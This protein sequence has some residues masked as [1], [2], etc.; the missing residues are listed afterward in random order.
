LAD[1]AGFSKGAKKNE[2]EVAKFFRTIGYEVL[3]DFVLRNLVESDF[4]YAFYYLKKHEKKFNGFKGLLSEVDR[5]K[6][7]RLYY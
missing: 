6:V 1:D 2:K 4:E 7:R 5:R 3:K